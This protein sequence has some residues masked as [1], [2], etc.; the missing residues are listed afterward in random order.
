MIE[1][2]FVYGTLRRGETNHHLL[3]GAQFCGEHMT[4]P[5]YR[6]LHLG[7]YP[8][9]VKG[10]STAI[11]GEI[12]RVNR[13]QFIQLDRLEAYPALY[14]RKL[15]PTRWGKAWIYLYRGNR[16]AR[17]V[18]PSGNWIGQTKQIGPFSL[19]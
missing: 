6:M 9:V 4:R 5:H 11:H 16:N 17:P 10:G 18:I 13:K 7:T 2:V 1:L 15:I 8:G 12:Y 3:H 19:Y 14:N